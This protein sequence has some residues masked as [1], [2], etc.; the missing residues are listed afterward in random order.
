[1]FALTGIYIDGSHMSA[2][3]FQV[4][5]IR[6]ANDRGYEIDS[7]QMDKDV[8]WMN[9][10][11]DDEDTLL[12][13]LDSLDWTYE[14]ALEYLNRIDGVD[15]LFWTVEDNSLFLEEHND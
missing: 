1:M 10:D 5:V 7:N 14:G 9:S 3:D 13:I 11:L 4:A 2:V 12:D 8:E 15:G 6:F